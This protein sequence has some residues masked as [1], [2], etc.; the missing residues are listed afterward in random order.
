MHFG[1]TMFLDFGF[2]NGGSD[3]FLRK[4]ATSR[5][6][7]TNVCFIQVA[8]QTGSSTPKILASKPKLHFTA[9]YRIP[10][11]SWIKVSWSKGTTYGVGVSSH[12]H[13]NHKLFFF[14]IDVLILI[15]CWK[16]S[17]CVFFFAKMLVVATFFRGWVC[18][19]VPEIDSCQSVHARC[20]QSWQ[21]QD[22]TTS[23]VAGPAKHSLC[24]FDHWV[25]DQNFHYDII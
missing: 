24:N 16:N 1:F 14:W 10:P 8:L 25:C 7:F 21:F 4:T 15:S 5:L 20:K 6:E 22:T 2:R 3:W 19:S 13:W 11:E 23:C 17:R 9:T 12:Q 18:E